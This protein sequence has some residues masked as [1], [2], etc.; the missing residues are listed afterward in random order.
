MYDSVLSQ[1]CFYIIVPIDQV[2]VQLCIG[3]GYDLTFEFEWK[4]GRHV[5]NDTISAFP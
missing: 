1:L 2:F 5:L 4:D 3:G